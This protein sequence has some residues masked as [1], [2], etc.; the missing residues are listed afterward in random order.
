MAEI[1]AGRSQIAHI[2]S[3]A[4]HHDA[5]A[6]GL[7]LSQHVR[8]E[9]LEGQFGLGQVDLQRHSA[10]GVGQ[11]CRG[12]DEADLPAHG[13]DDKYGVGRHDPEFS[14]LAWRM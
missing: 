6:V 9:L 1:V 7:E 11:T 5:T 4:D 13:L 2:E 14:S 12:R 3:L 8:A 10:L